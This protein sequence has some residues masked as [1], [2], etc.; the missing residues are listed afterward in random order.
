[1]KAQITLKKL[2][3]ITCRSNENIFKR[4]HIRK[5]ITSS[6]KIFYSGIIQLLD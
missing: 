5:N 4:S 2:T 6:G 3:R 1:M